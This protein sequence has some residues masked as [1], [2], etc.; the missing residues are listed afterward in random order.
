VSATYV[1]AACGGTFDT[2]QDDEKAHKEALERYGK[3]GTAP[4][5]AKVCDECYAKI[6]AFEN[7]FRFAPKANLN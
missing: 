1:C 2:D 3:D 6:V 7:A 4:D 5:M